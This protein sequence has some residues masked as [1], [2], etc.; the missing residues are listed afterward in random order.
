M[1]EARGERWGTPERKRIGLVSCPVPPGFLPRLGTARAGPQKKKDSASGSHWPGRP[2]RPRPLFA[3][4]ASRPGGERRR[5]WARKPASAGIF[6]GRSG[7][8]GGGAEGAA[9]RRPRRGSPPRKTTRVGETAGCPRSAIVQAGPVR[10]FMAG[11][12][13]CTSG[14]PPPP[15]ALSGGEEEKKHHKKKAQACLGQKNN[16]A[17]RQGRGRQGQSLGETT[18]PSFWPQPT[19]QQLAA[20]PSRALKCFGPPSRI[21]MSKT[22]PKIK[23]APTRNLSRAR[24][25]SPRLPLDF[26]AAGVHS[27]EPPAGQAVRRIRIQG[28]A[29]DGKEEG[30]ISEGQVAPTFLSHSQGRHTTVPLE[31]RG[32]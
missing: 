12:L 32:G 21:Y 7:S 9:P 2:P 25:P 16:S 6:P 31:G 5:C 4:G 15:C 17:R 3:R 26:L 24:T 18:V 28:P 13:G 10:T 20:T 30:R 23:K 29:V 8:G 1:L 14:G 11:R 22:R 27:H 19:Q